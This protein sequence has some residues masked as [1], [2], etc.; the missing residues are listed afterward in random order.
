MSECGGERE[1]EGEDVVICEECASQCVLV[2]CVV[3]WVLDNENDTE[4]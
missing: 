3:F 1:A 4:R 2:K